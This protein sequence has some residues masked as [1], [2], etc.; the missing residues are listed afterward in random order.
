[1]IILFTLEG[2]CVIPLI[3][4]WLQT[5]KGKIEEDTSLNIGIGYAI[6][7]SIINWICYAANI[8]GLKLFIAQGF[9]ESIIDLDAVIA[10]IIIPGI[11][12]VVSYAIF[13]LIVITK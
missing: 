4:I 1:M 9:Y 6:V 10:A 3:F 2:L 8:S 13:I 5:D 11:T 12:L 7:A